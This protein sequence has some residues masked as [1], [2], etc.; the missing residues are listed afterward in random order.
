V[1]F[2]QEVQSK[3]L[4]V[5]PSTMVFRLVCSQGL[6]LLPFKLSWCG[7]FLLLILFGIAGPIPYASAQDTLISAGSS[8]R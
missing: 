5:F 1:Y 7:G 6:L 8:W 3:G 4:K 2:G